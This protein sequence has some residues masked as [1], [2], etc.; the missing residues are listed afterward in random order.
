MLAY[1]T[2]LT[3]LLLGAS[4]L[5]PVLADGA[6]I[7]TAI[8]AIQNAT[9]ALGTTVSSWDGGILGA[10]PIVGDSTSLLGTINDGTATAKASANLS[11]LEALTVGLAVIQLN[12]D[13]NTT[14]TTLVASK[15]KFDR[16]LL[17]PI[18]LLNLEQEKSASEGFSDALLA[19]LPAS[20]V[21][22]GETLAAEISA[23][24][25]EAIDVYSGGLL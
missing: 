15:G 13:V 14:L 21:E 18:V 11:D 17:T 22:T 25:D 3:T 19:K 8:S 1:K 5:T 23:S 9:L 20:F 2:F 12:T 6:A 24:F 16:T 7:A 10:L 4:T